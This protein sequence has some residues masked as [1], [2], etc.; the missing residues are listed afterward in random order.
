MPD[1]IITQAEETP[2]A[3]DKDVFVFPNPFSTEINIQ[4]VRKGLSF[5]LYNVSGHCILSSEII[6]NNNNTL[7]TGNLNPG[8]YFY[9]IQYENHIIQSGKIIKE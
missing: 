8:S 2:F 4:T 3:F 7:S 6:Y 5:N 1:D 9:N